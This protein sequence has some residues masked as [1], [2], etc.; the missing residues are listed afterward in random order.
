MKERLEQ[1]IVNGIQCKRGSHV[2]FRQYGLNITDQPERL[3]RI[4][5][6]ELCSRYYPDVIGLSIYQKSESKYDVQIKAI[7]DE[8]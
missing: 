3:R 6:L 8:A 4:Q 7:G 5:I 1:C 2:L